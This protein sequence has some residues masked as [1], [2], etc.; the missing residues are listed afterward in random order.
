MKTQEVTINVNIQGLE[1]LQELVDVLEQA[2]D[3]VEYI[4]GSEFF[5]LYKEER[6]NTM[7]AKKRRAAFDDR[8]FSEDFLEGL[9]NVANR[10]QKE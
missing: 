9:I 7:E 8:D 2:S 5:K 1:D 4:E 3:I 10:E 6:E